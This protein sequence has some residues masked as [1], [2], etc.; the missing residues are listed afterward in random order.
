MPRLFVL[1]LLAAAAFPAAAQVRGAMPMGGMGRMGHTRVSTPGIR[2]GFHANPQ[3]SGRFFHRGGFFNAP[4]FYPAYD[5]YPPDDYAQED[6]SE[7]PPQMVAVPVPQA[8]PAR[9]PAH[10]APLVIEWQGDRFV[11][12]GGTADDQMVDAQGRWA[13]RSSREEFNLRPQA[14]SARPSAA[15]PPRLEPPATVLVFRDGRREETANYSIIGG[16]LYAYADYWTGGSWAKKIQISEL[17]LPAT[18]RSNDE[19]GVKFVLPPGPNQI[20]TRF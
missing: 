15:L 5:D 8:L 6:P 4:F 10:S 3:F 19:R 16:T 18:V 2:I 12:Y 17:D 13:P 1:A 14:S 11:R 9:E 20:V 7:V